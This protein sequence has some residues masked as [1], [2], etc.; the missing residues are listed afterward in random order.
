MTQQVV[1]ED[2]TILSLLQNETLATQI[3]CFSNKKSL[4]QGVRGG[5]CGACARKR[6]KKQQEEMAKIKSCLVALS[7][8]KKE[9][10]KNTLNTKQIKVVYTNTSGQTTSVTF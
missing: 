8:E 2:S 1:L 7:V 10:L 5:G 4:F 6:M 3:P 9:L